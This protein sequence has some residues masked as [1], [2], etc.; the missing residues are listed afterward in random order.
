MK[1]S[2]FRSLPV[3]TGPV[4]TGIVLSL[5]LLFSLPAAA[6]PRYAGMVVDLENG[7]VLYAA[8]ADI[9]RYPASLTKMM[10][11]YLV[12]EAL[13]RGNLE[14]NQALP[15]SS[16]AAA[17]PAVKLW[18]P[19][20]G[21]IKVDEAIRAMVVR[22]AN[23][24]AVVVAEALGGSERQ[25]AHLMTQKARELGMHST[26]FRNASGL[27]DDQQATTARDMLTLSV[28]VMEDFPQY[29][30]YFSLQEFTYRGTRHTSH[31]RLVKNYPGA[32]GLKTGF[33]RASGFNVA[34]TAVRGGRRLMA[35]VMGGFTAQSRDAHMADLLDRGFQRASLRDRGNWLA[36]ASISQ[37]YMEFP[38]HAAPYRQQ[39][40]SGS[41]M[42][43]VD[44]SNTPARRSSQSGESVAMTQ[45]ASTPPS[46]VNEPLAAADD[47]LQRFM[48]RERDLAATAAGHWGI[49]VGAFSQAE[50]ARHLAQQ[51]AQRVSQEFQQARI[52]V[53][54][55]QEGPPVYRARLVDLH[56]EQAH[57][58]CTR[59]Q[60][61]GMDC[62]VV[63]ASL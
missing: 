45:P 11:L 18:L 49:Q 39:S 17:M 43:A 14:L 50:H 22:S 57:R 44:I 51:A 31:N 15:V 48:Q 7:E 23:D 35:I 29:Y 24:V 16:Q 59:L 33:I 30:H 1:V 32:D 20:G 28:R 47:P 9:R 41:L 10:T 42:A 12:F 8:N 38:G 4:V 5:C 2:A 34:T 6:N 46:G 53:D 26:T 62:M 19:A 60:A 25:F 37:E 3:F 13:E 54:A 36:N 61:E 52:A 55:L 27:P 21:S 63:N 58:A 40:A 56:E